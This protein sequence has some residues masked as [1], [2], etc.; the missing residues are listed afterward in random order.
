MLCTVSN[1]QNNDLVLSLGWG[2]T[3]ESWEGDINNDIA[4]RLIALL[5]V[6]TEITTK[7]I[8]VRPETLFLIR[9]CRMSEV[10]LRDGNL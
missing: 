2:C 3:I 6:K 1:I 8:S 4:F 10:S 7:P 5:S 9:E